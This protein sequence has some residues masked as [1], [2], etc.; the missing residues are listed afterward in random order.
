[1][2]TFQE[3]RALLLRHRTDY[4]KAVEL[5]PKAETYWNTLGAA[6]YRAGEAE[7]H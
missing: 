1:M 5:A 4:N 3:A 7:L 2:T 6:Q